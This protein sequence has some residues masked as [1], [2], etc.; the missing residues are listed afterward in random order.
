MTP[1][2]TASLSPLIEARRKNRLLSVSHNNVSRVRIMTAAPTREVELGRVF[3]VLKTGKL[4]V[5]PSHSF[6]TVTSH[7]LLITIHHTL[8][9]LILTS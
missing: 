7:H 6:A 4:L 5:A 8:E 2:S 1:L 3:E 9:C